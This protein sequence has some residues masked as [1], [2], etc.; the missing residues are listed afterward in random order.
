MNKWLAQD[1]YTYCHSRESNPG[2][3]SEGPTLYGLSYLRCNWNINAIC[4]F[5]FAVWLEH[6]A[7]HPSFGCDLDLVLA[8]HALDDLELA[9]H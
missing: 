5:S 3:A 7:S 1:P 9:G 6:V 4:Y 8:G 2:L